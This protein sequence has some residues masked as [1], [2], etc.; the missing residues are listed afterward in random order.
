[1]RPGPASPD[2]PTPGMDRELGVPARKCARSRFRTARRRRRT[3]GEFKRRPSCPSDAYSVPGNARVPVL[4]RHEHEHEH[5]CARSSLGHHA[6]RDYERLS[7]S[8]KPIFEIALTQERTNFH[9]SNL[10]NDVANRH[11]PPQVSVDLNHVSS[12]QLGIP[13]LTQPLAAPSCSLSQRPCAGIETINFMQ[14]PISH[15]PI[16]SIN[17]SDNNR[18]LFRIAPA[19]EGRIR[20]PL[21]NQLS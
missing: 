20:P 12:H 5:E 3:P 4:G 21:R 7:I 2:E 1:V 10:A 6:P 14:L 15:K 18:Q 13:I 8:T 19:N 17:L 11:Q 9:C 16:A